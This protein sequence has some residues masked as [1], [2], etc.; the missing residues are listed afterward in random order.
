MREIFFCIKSSVSILRYVTAKFPLD[1][2]CY[3]TRTTAHS[4]DE[5]ADFGNYGH[6]N[7]GKAIHKDAFPAEA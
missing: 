6:K 4:H 2:F 1:R 7:A 3:L 5:M